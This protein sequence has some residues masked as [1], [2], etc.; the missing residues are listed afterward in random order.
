MASV[1]PF[2]LLGD[3]DNDD[4]SH[5]LEA[6][7]HKLSPLAAKKPQA[8][9]AAQPAKLAKLPSKPLPPAQAGNVLAESKRYPTLWSREQ[10]RAIS[11]AMRFL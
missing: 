10:T 1:N 11:S 4:S 9:P 7:E 8:Q 2:D 6:Q 5:L 3:D